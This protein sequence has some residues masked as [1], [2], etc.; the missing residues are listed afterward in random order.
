VG[1]G[2]AADDRGAGLS[3]STKVVWISPERASRVDPAAQVA[4]RLDTILRGPRSIA[5]V[6]FR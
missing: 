4:M 1:E 3:P 5:L 6:P 2:F